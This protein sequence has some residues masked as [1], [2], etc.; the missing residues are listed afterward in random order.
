MEDYKIYKR[1]SKQ[2]RQYVRQVI[3]Q[4]NSNGKKTLLL[5]ADNAYPVVDGVWRVLC[6]CA[7][8][9]CGYDD[10]NVVFMGPDYKGDVYVGKFPVIGVKSVYIS[11]MHYQMAL[12]ML[13]RQAQR[14]L[15]QLRIDVIHCHSPFLC[16]FL[17]RK[18]HKKRGVPMIS[19]FHSQFRQ[20]FMRATKSKVL[21]NALLRHIMKVFNDSD[22]V[23]TMHTAS[24]DTLYS[25]GYNGSC[26]LMPNATSMKPLDNYD[27]V[28]TNFRREHGLQNKVMFL[29]VGRVVLQKGILFIAD[30]L[31]ILKEKGVD[32]TMF[33]VGD[34][35]DVKRMK[36]KVAACNLQ[37][38]VIFDGRFLPPEQLVPFYA[39]ADLFLFP[40][41]YDVS[42]IVQIEAATFRTPTVFSEGS[43]TSCVVTPN[44][45][46][47]VLPYDV[48]AYAQG[49]L[50]ILKEGSY[51]KVGQQALRD[52]HVEWE[53]V[54]ED[55][56]KVYDQ[57]IKSDGE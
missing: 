3:E 11:D 36:D 18:I 43:V 46:G 4:Y 41:K 38:N 49:V 28:R 21:T 31:K 27:E 33:V 5:V 45:N 26:R 40:S 34:G 47:Y 25:Y 7:E 57:Y 6:S 13:D 15:K 23:W 20:D 44:V 16:G 54:V 35:P 30:V 53:K 55:S 17:A 48:Q 14:W 51:E 52:L 1:S 50:D 9:L 22:E 24:K 12:P 56:V 32:F 42:S 2:Y 8:I 39:A 19:T 10:Y 37:K 29:F